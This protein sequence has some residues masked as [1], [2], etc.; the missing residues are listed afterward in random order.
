MDTGTFDLD[1]ALRAA[2]DA[3]ALGA[4]LRS[5][6]RSLGEYEGRD[7]KRVITAVVDP[8]G[9][10]ERLEV[11]ESW[12]TRLAPSDF[13]HAV[14][15][16]AAMA[17]E[18]YA[19]AFGDALTEAFDS[20]SAVDAEPA[21]RPLGLDPSEFFT[22]DL[23]VAMDRLTRLAA[24][25]DEAVAA[26]EAAARTEDPAP[27]GDALGLG[28]RGMVELRLHPGGGLAGCEIDLSW[29]GRCPH[30]MLCEELTDALAGAR[31]SREAAGL[32]RTEGIVR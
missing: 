30:W 4:R 19:K 2:R 8:T 3:Q 23:D 28:E 5:M 13:P 29:L 22:S 31:R 25:A 21:F 18:A 32:A 15:E 20:S 14:V 12:R 11:A 6:H 10:L 17:D 7:P 26:A 16:A 9:T 1:G 24:L 27:P